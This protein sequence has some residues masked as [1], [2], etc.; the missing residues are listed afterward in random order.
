MA[1]SMFGSS[2]PGWRWECQ[3]YTAQ[4]D[5]KGPFLPDYEAVRSCSTKLAI[6]M[7]MRMNLYA[8]V[9]KESK[10][11]TEHKTEPEP[12][13]QSW[14]PRQSGHVP[15]ATYEGLVSSLRCY[16]EVPEPLGGG[17]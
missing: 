17:A 8:A 11:G 7:D 1:G 16:W 15:E 2:S 14:S 13:T 3:G 4:E 12:L 9:A 5:G 10:A 6:P